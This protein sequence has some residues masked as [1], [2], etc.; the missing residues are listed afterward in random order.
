MFG[1]S[2]FG[3]PYF[4]QGG[5]GAAI[6]QVTGFRLSIE[7]RQITAGSDIP[8]GGGPFRWPLPIRTREGR[9]TFSGLRLSLHAG[10][11]TA[12]TAGIAARPLTM[13]CKSRR[14]T[15]QGYKTISVTRATEVIY[16]PSGL[17]VEEE[18][19]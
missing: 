2:Q 12:T 14:V 16:F 1:A 5:D 4:G 3:Q 11:V 15:A 9:A 10:K 6:A 19:E 7:L 17:S 18:E 8:V 13:A